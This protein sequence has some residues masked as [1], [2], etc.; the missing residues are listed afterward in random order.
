MVSLEAF[1]DLLQVLYSAPL[2]QELWQ[3][4]LT[5]VCEYTRSNLGVFISAD[6]R[7]GLA[8]L[9][10]GGGR[11]DLAN[12]SIYNQQFAQKDPFRPPIVRRC[13]TRNPVGVY[14]ENDLVPSQEFL[15]SE[16]YLGLLGPANLRYAAITVL[17]C[18]VRKLDAIS[19]WRTPEEGPVDADSLHLLELLIPH[20][21]T[22]L[23]VRRALGTAE[24][25]QASAEAMANASPT[26][27]F[28][29]TRDGLV[30]HYNT[31]AE[32]L[33]RGNEILMIENGRLT[34]TRL[35]DRAAMGKLFHDAVAPSYSF[36]KPRTSHVLSLDRAAAKQPL[37]LL[38]T[39]LPE[40]HRQRSQADLLLMISD[41]E[42]PASFPDDILH[43]LYGLTP[44]E[45]E[46][47]NG[48]LMGYSVDEIA[49]LRRVAT[50]TIRQQVKSML[51][52]TGTNRQSDMV[53][54]FMT[55]PQTPV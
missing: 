21:Q 47:A 42:K 8:V 44:A 12:V 7:S 24:Q 43:A 10:A 3:R 53:R 22:A 2:Q 32:S 36:S 37:Q 13:R 35:A 28:V 52:K 31:A 46:V 9:A 50:S 41:P 23:R 5:R 45:T 30:Q 38:A 39:L 51:D 15:Q 25:R 33:I 16:I 14:T 4:F 11:N 40:A 27:T 34:A 6:T 26:A 55:L 54:M 1:S 19:F 48:L 29:L 18:T 20:V 49:C 17:A